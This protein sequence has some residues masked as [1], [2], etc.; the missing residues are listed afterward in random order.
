[1]CLNGGNVIAKN[2]L[3]LRS[4]ERPELISMAVLWEYRP[5]YFHSI[6]NSGDYDF[7]S[8]LLNAARFT[9]YALLHTHLYACMRTEPEGKKEMGTFVAISD[10]RHYWT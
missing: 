3:P 1:M 6:R 10:M 5:S 2:V 8:V 7:Y 4:E 9:K